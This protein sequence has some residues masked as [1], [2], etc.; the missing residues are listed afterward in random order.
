MALGFGFNKQKV[1]ASAEKA[2]QQGK[3]QNAIN[4]YEKVV[5]EDPKDLTVL[6]T[7]GDLHA[8][9]GNNDKAA[10]FFK[11][12]GDIYA[13]EGFTVKAIAVYKKI[14]KLN[15]NANECVQK[16]AE[17]YTQQGLYNDAKQQYVILADSHMRVANLEDAAADDDAIGGF[18]DLAGDVQGQGIVQKASVVG[19]QSSVV[20]HQEKQTPDPSAARSFASLGR[21]P[22]GMTK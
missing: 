22:L 17:L 21:A 1:L 4:E 10:V 20:S 3:L 5:K 7:I 11:R 16:L 15:P 9:V 6:N 14:T 2:V 12:V 19:R 13:T 18:R 8:R